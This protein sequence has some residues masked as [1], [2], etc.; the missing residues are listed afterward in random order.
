GTDGLNGASG[1]SASGGGIYSDGGLVILTNSTVT[2][3]QAVGGAGSQGPSATTGHDASAGGFGGSAHG[4]GIDSAH[5]QLRVTGCTISNNQ[6]TGGAGAHGGVADNIGDSGLN[7]G[8]GGAGGDA[9]GGGIAC[10]SGAV[11]WVVNSTVSN[12]SAVAGAGG[13]GGDSAS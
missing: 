11:A 5:G 10:D 8:D 3:N 4:G 12:D 1:Q 9:V 2:K 7:G 6:A 13:I